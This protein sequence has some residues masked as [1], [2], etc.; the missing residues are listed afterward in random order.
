[1]TNIPTRWRVGIGA[2]ASGLIAVALVVLYFREDLLGQHYAWSVF[3]Q[4][5]TR[6]FHE[7]SLPWLSWFI[8]KGGFFIMWVGVCLVLVR[9]WQA[10]IL[11]LVGPGTLLLFLYVWNP[12]VSTRL[13]WFVRRFVPSV[14]P[15]VIIL[16]AI[17]IGWVITRRP[18]LAKIAG[19]VA[20]VSLI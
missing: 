18:V 6:S 10:T 8:T 11:A 3:T 19:V 9:R 13:M 5:V 1:P 17:A 12:R 14:L 16:I 4:D 20:A 15:A 7:R 2:V